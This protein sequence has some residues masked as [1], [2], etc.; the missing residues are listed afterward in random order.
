VGRH[1]PVQPHGHSLR[2]ELA[3]IAE[4]NPEGPSRTQKHA[5]KS[6]AQRAYR[7]RLDNPHGHRD[8]IGDCY[9][10]SSSA[11]AR[12]ASGNSMPS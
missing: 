3:K 10:I 6:H 9:L 8:R 4:A 12:S 7:R 5:H 11:V 2:D 1:P